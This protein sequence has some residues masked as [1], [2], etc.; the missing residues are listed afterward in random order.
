MRNI[1]G[2][3]A[4]GVGQIVNM[5]QNALAVYQDS[6]RE[7]RMRHDDAAIR[8]LESVAPYPPDPADMH[9]MFIV[10]RWAGALL[11][12]PQG[13]AAFTNLKRLLTDVASAPEYSLAD[14]IG[15]VRGQALSGEILFPQLATLDLKRL[16]PDFRLPVFFLEGREDPYCRPALIW[17]YSQ[18]I[19][20]PRKAF[21]WFENSGHYPFYDQ[22]REFGDEL[23]RLLLPLVP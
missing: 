9:S 6:L 2:Y 4:L 16:G 5:R 10:N 15:F 19:E 20:A 21:V 8:A 17:E 7:A 22:Q 13:A 11:G 23:A 1:P 14:V 12:P 3:I 18:F